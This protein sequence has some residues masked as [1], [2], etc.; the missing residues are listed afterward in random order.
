MAAGSVGT[1]QAGPPV[2]VVR[3]L[4]KR[5]W[6]T[7]AL[8]D[9]DLD[10]VPGQ[11]HALLGQN[12]AGKST[13]IKVLAGVYRPDAGSVRLDGADVL[14]ADED[15]QLAFIHQDLGLVPSMTVAENIAL[16]RGYPRRGKLVSWSQVRNRAS[17]VLGTIGLDISPE[18]DV[19]ELTMAQRS[20]V[21]IS[22][23][24][25]AQARFVSWMSRPPRFRPAMW[26]GWSP[27]SSG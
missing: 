27:P 14:A 26:T 19:S 5:F 1:A 18:A 12:G 23:A 10:L 8:D 13:L 6:G 9:V 25:S 3:G 11:V 16:V 4:S 20:L 22:R 7:R 21:A 2:L 15:A 17:E 24:L